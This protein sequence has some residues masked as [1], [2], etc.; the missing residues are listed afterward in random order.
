[1]LFLD[2]RCR[3]LKADS[4]LACNGG[5]REWMMFFCD[6][7]KVCLWFKHWSVITWFSAYSADFGGQHK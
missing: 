2:N 3:S 4:G 6:L 7:M 1:M 5:G